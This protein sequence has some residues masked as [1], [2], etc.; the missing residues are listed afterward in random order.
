MKDKKVTPCREVKYGEFPEL[1][2]GI[3]ANGMVYF[4]ATDYIRRK[5]EVSPRVMSD[6]QSGFAFWIKALGSAYSL[7]PEEMFIRDEESGDILMEESLALLFVAC[8]DPEFAVYMLE[9]ISEMLING[10]VLSDTALRNMARER[11]TVNELT[12]KQVDEKTG[13]Q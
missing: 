4:N 10:I 9:R 11:G 6:F 3:G 7:S 13:K 5:G 2:F 1:L 12:G 8:L